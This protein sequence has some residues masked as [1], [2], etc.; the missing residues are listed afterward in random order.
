[1][2]KK[3]RKKPSPWDSW[4][5]RQLVR[6]G[7]TDERVLKVFSEVSRSPFISRVR[8]G[9][10]FDDSPIPI[11]CR[12]T[13]S[14]PYIIALSL[15]ALELTGEERVLDVGTGSGFQA[16]LLSHLAKEVFTIEIHQKLF[17]KAK[18][19]IE[20]Q[21]EASVHTRMGDGSIGWPEEAP[22]DGI[23]VGS[24]APEIPESLLEQLVV[25][26]R[27]V[28]PVGGDSVQ[29]LYQITKQADGE[30]RKKI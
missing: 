6:R 3:L 11:G 25:G 5:N 15:Q 10:A 21:M 2:L 20:Q 30:I 26:G 14:Q 16:I 22:F 9:M 4:I 13:V 19:V 17:T 28:I 7:I 8:R 1:M 18:M 29:T 27:M 12:Q 23:V 24:R